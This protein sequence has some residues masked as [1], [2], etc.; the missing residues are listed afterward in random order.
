MALQVGDWVK[1]KASV[2]AP[3]YGWEDV[4]RNSIGIIHYLEDDGD[5]GVAFC[6]TSKLFCCSVSD[7]EKVQ[8]FSIGQ[9]IHVNPS[10]L[11]PRLGWSNETVASVGKISRIDMDGT[12]NVSET[13]IT[14]LP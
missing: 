11:Q 1:V 12:L 5:M 3:K 7:M 13:R 14:S 4:T 8:P 2:S 9:V 6:F 10:I